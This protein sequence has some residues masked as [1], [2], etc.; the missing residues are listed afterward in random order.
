MPENIFFVVPVETVSVRSGCSPSH[1]VAKNGLEL[2]M[3]LLLLPDRRG[4]CQSLFSD[5]VIPSASDQV[6]GGW[7]GQV[8]GDFI[9]KLWHI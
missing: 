5:S 3:T 4:M 7:G 9:F 2:L 8:E 6:F 1:S